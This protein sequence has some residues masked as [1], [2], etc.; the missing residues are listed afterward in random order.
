MLKRVLRSALRVNFRHAATDAVIVV[1]SFYFSLYLRASGTASFT[2]FL[3]SITTLIPLY[4]AIRL[5]TFVSVGIYDI[6]WRYVSFRDASKLVRGVFLSTAFIVSTTYFF[7]VG[8]PR[9]IF[10]IDAIVS[11]LLLIGVRSL[12]RYLYER[13][14]TRHQNMDEARRVLIYGAGYN[15][16]ILASRLQSDPTSGYE[17]IGFIDD[18]PG[19]ISRK[20]GGYPVRG[21][22]QDLEEVVSTYKVQEV[23]VAITSAPNALLRSIYQKTGRFNIR[24]RLITS[25][26]GGGNSRATGELY[27]N[28]EL[29]D[30]LSREP[31]SLNLDLTRALV[32]GKRILITGA[33]GSI[34]SELA[35]QVHNFSPAQ[36]VILDHS[37][38]NLYQIDNEL[39]NTQSQTQSVVPVLADIK[40][41]S[42]LK[43][44]VFTYRPEIV[45]HAA[46]YKHVHLVEANPF[47]AILN[48]I[49]GTKNLVDL[50]LEV[51][52]K[53]FVQISTDKAVNPVGVMGATKRVCELIVTDAGLRSAR[54]YCSVRFGNVLGSSGSLIPLLQKQI[55]DGEPIT[56]TH[57]D[58]TRYFM[59]IP[60]AVSL[61]LTAASFTENG[62]IAIL[63]MGEPIKIVE[64]AKSLI[65]LM[66]KNEDDV[67]IVYTGL[68]PGEKMFEELCLTGK[69]RETTHPNIMILGGG[70]ASC[71][72]GSETI[73]R[74]VDSILNGAK[75]HKKAAIQELMHLLQLDRNNEAEAHTITND[76]AARLVQ[77][78]S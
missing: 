61:V 66:G 30:L 49:E 56:I 75:F 43:E 38:F 36:L 32:K 3:K 25:F 64:I 23:I 21:N 53:H 34:G 55:Q 41:R 70:D 76:S 72:L 44:A 31:K 47:A 28:I 9:S 27:R 37:E 77:V 69:E 29:S 4:L 35:R 63:K 26:M 54:H 48:N 1:F 22:L 58:M 19:K 45:F 6:I 15:G 10:F 71:W 13:S 14:Q 74:S 78:D 51:D 67:S 18:D 11:I 57:K 33:G 59:L 39:R 16:R 60:E 42:Q 68:R 40:D 7:D 8:L 52:V 2:E 24:P 5:M 12:R 20:I 62:D 73:A 17:V 65:A 46:A 50:C